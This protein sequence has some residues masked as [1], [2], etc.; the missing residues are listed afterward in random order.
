MKLNVKIEDIAFGTSIQSIK[1]PDLLKK[2]VP[3]GLG[4]FDYALGGK[5]F[6]PSLCGLFTGT[7]GAGKTTMFN[8]ITG[9]LSPDKGLV[10]FL[11]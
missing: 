8:L 2:R 11:G 1:V 10:Y 7:P 3:S 6:T 9:T 4:Y 5:G